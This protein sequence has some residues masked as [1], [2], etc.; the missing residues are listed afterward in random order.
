MTRGVGSDAGAG[1]CVWVG[2]GVSGGEGLGAGPPGCAEWC[3]DL[4]GVL[5]AVCVTLAVCG[6]GGVG[7]GR[8]RQDVRGCGPLVKLLGG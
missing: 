7:C 4:S 6:A 3:S 8:P 2:V 1:V 5:L